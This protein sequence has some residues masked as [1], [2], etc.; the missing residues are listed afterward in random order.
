MDKVKACKILGI[1]ERTLMAMIANNQI[2]AVKKVIN[3]KLRYDFDPDEIERVRLEREEGTHVAALVRQ[4]PQ[5]FLD[6]LAQPSQT[7]PSVLNDPQTFDALSDWRM[8]QLM[9]SLEK[10]LTLT[11]D[12]ASV[13]SGLGKGFIRQAIEDGKLTAVD[14]AGHRG[15]TIIK[16]SDLERFVEGL[17]KGRRKRS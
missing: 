9:T 2:S 14:G 15:A 17:G 3:K 12:E 8:T 4:S 13:Y 5:V 6:R 11:I 1:S 10:K 16:R 7:Q